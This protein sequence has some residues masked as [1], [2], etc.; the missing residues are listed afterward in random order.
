MRSPAEIKADLLRRAAEAGFDDC[1]IAAADA[2]RHAGEFR[3]W[4]AVGAAGEM[5]WIAR[6]A[7]KRCDP[8]MVLPGVRSVVTLA[9]NYWQG[10]EDRRSQ[11]AATNGGPHR[12]LCV[13]R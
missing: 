13:G 9:M 10:D 3:A 7:G 2:P 1:R 12:S 4:L 8:Q 11:T 5:D 6:G